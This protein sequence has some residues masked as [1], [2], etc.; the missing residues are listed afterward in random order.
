MGSQA[1]TLQ[2]VLGPCLLFV[3]L[4]FE[5]VPT[6]GSW[7]GSAGCWRST[8]AR[9]LAALW[10]VSTMAGRFV[11]LCISLW[12]EPGRPD[13]DTA[14]AEHKLSSDDTELS[15]FRDLI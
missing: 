8:G 5:A 13:P 3:V 1:R 7:A 10:V 9:A 15:L 14:S 12:A 11:T 6:K 4:G 2:R